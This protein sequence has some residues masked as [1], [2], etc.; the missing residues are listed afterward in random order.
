MN[1]AYVKMKNNSCQQKERNLSIE[2]LKFIAVIVVINS[3][4]D[5]MYGKYSFLATG[6]AIGDCLFFFASGF[7]IFLGRAGRF[8]NW[9]K[10]RI[11]RIYPSL[12]ALSLILPILGSAPM[13]VIKLIS[14]GGAWFVSCIMLY[15]IPLYLIKTLFEKS[16]TLPFTTSI[17]CILIWYYFEDR[18]TF[19]MYGD[20]YFKWLHF[21]IF[22]LL[23]AYTGN[24]VIRLKTNFAIDILGLAISILTFYGLSFAAT[25]NDLFAQFQILT[26][27]P[28]SGTVIFTYKLC[29]Q[30]K[31][32]TIMRTKC[33]IVLRFIAGLC[34]EIYLIQAVF[35]TDKLNHIFPLNLIIVFVEIITASYLLRCVSKIILQIFQKE[36][37]NWKEV[38]RAV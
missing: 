26:I 9:Y 10:R 14:G 31:V 17:I 22:M 13:D 27:I 25:T 38:F 24:G 21:F 15:Y 18:H 37:F 12:I 6:G 4:C 8:D 2:L 32:D 30:E 28:L 35:F 34:L 11:Q 19:F 16:P 1:E 3:H 33:G 23:G 20:T 29:K 7:T 36:D 5:I